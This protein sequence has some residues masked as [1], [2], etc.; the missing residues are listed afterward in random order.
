MNITQLIAQF[1][2]EAAD[3]AT[4]YLWSDAVV[5]GYFNEAV[6]EA[7][8]RKDLIYESE[9][10]M[11]E[12]DVESGE[13]S[14][15]LSEYITRV[16]KAYLVAS[17]DDEYTYL[18]ITDRDTLDTIDSAWRENTDGDPKYLVVEDLKVWL[19]PTPTESYTLWLEAYRT[20]IVREQMIAVVAPAT[21]LSPKIGLAH[22]Q[23]LFHWACHRA[24][25]KRDIDKYS[26]Q[27]AKDHE[28]KFENYF[29][30]RPNADRKRK[31][32][33]NRPHRNTLW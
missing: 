15:N 1:R 12:L 8:R 4:P 33:E 32:R 23:Y 30:T 25:N 22:H 19:A 21:A 31:T 20:P 6:D 18:D 24:Y 11:C 28:E 13:K 10:G 2:E 9:L 27:L 3:A 7:C 16:D 5:I 17:D 26:P 14:Y 29:G